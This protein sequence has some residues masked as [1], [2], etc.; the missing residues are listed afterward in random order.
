MLKME[1]LIK[2]KNAE[3]ELARATERYIKAEDLIGTYVGNGLKLSNDNRKLV[4][5]NKILL[6]ENYKLAAELLDLYRKLP[7]H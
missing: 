7:R 2:L 4:V 6:K 1:A 5:E 3:A